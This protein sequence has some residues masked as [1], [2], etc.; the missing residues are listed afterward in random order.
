VHASFA[1]TLRQ[2]RLASGLT[3]E[4]LAERAG[5]SVRTISDLERGIKQVP[6]PSTMR[7]IVRGLGLRARGAVLRAALPTPANSRT[8]SRA[9]RHNLP[10][11]ISSFVGREFAVA[12]LEHLLARVRMVTLTGAGGVG[13]TRL[14]LAVAAGLVPR[15]ADGVWL[16]ELA[17][18]ANPAV[19][20]YVACSALGLRTAPGRPPLDALRAAL[21]P[22]HALLVLDNCEHLLAACAD[23][24]RDLLGACPDLRVLT[25]SRQALGL[26][27]ETAWLVPSLTLPPASADVTA[28][29]TAA[30]SEAGRLFMERATAVDRAIDWDARTMAA[31]GMVC[32]RLDGIPLAIE[33]AAAWAHVLTV[34]E[35]ARRLAA[36]PGLLVGSRSAAPR[37]RTLRAT[38]EW[39]LALLAEHE[40]RLF[41]QLSV[42]AGGFT[43]DAAGAVT[44]G[45]VLAPLA[46]LVA[47]SLVQRE[48]EA[49]GSGRYRLLEPLRQLGQ[50]HLERAPDASATRDRHAEYFL[51]LSESVQ[52]GLWGRGAQG[53]GV[54]RL[55]CEVDNLRSALTWFV[56]SGHAEHAGRLGAGLARFW[57]FSGRVAEGRI[58]LSQLLDLAG[59]SARTRG[60]LLVAAGA[61]ATY[62]FDLAIAHDLLEAGLVS[63]REAEDHW[64]TAWALFLFAWGALIRP[65]TFDGE[66]ILRLCAEGAALGRAA[67]D[68]VLELMHNLTV[69]GVQVRSDQAVQAEATAQRGLEQARHVGAPREQARAYMFLGAACYSQGKLASAREMLERARTAW[70][71]EGE[72]GEVPWFQTVTG[73]VLVGSDAGDWRLARSSLGGLLELWAQHGRLPQLAYACLM[74]AAYVAVAERQ[75]ERAVRIGA[76]LAAHTRAL[77]GLEYF[78]RSVTEVL[79]QAREALGEPAAAT[80]WAEGQALSLEQACEAARAAAQE[81]VHAERP[82][83]RGRLAGGLTDRE[84]QVLRLVAEGRTNRAVADALVL[85]EKTVAKHLDN[86]FTKLGVSSRAAAVAFALRAGLA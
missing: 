11:P 29:A 17:A 30:S 78:G 48:P 10:V 62:E 19:V 53:G 24:V 51:D 84:A 3:Q 85:S 81:S 27:G 13:K 47:G 28:E 42:F 25:T 12:E 44:G 59:V 67:G 22:K 65:E 77:G 57:L 39:S 7:L 43:L 8:A 16:V 83:G 49:A 37:H 50:L 31:V 46:R 79:R 15:Y 32:R 26:V 69:A 41:E 76:V 6:R 60:R 40:R 1:E 80:A 34:P 73:L 38:V 68:P 58:W 45:D 18:V 71:S 33:L 36:D 5:L 4:E 14:A 2:Q 61:A 63:T 82:R 20:P 21:Q 66:L 52:G 23:L 75:P 72:A 56:R 54:S 35:I 55:E 64:P 74:A 9:V 86:I 70:E